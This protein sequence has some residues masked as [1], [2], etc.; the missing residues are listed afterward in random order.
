[1]STVPEDDEQDDDKLPARQWLAHWFSDQ[2]FWE[3]V[4]Q[5]LLSTGILAAIGSLVTFFAAQ[6]AVVRTTGLSIGGVVIGLIVGLIVF[7]RASNRVAKR[8]APSP[9]AARFDPAVRSR[10]TRRANQSY[11]LVALASLA[12]TVAVSAGVIVGL[13]LFR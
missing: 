2:S 11:T 12:I 9:S 1:M 8:I 10:A 6:N 4:A 13:N 3:G 5:G 7:S